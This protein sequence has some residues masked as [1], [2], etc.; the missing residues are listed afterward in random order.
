[1]AYVLYTIQLLKAP[2]WLTL[3]SFLIAALSPYY[4]S[5]ITTIVKDT[6]YSFAVLLYLVELV[7]LHLDWKQYWKSPVHIGLFFSSN[8][9][10]ILLR[11]NG[12]YILYVMGIYLLSDASSKNLHFL[13]RALHSMVFC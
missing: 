12:K 10:M 2:Y 6:P 4:T 9:A 8:I 13:K 3:L 11:H 7:Y 1:M 5:Y